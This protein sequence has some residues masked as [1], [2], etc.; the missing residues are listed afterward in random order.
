[1]QH[2]R[3]YT[4]KGM[5]GILETIGFEQIESQGQSFHLVATLPFRLFSLLHGGNK[6]LRLLLCVVSLGRWK[7]EYPGLE[8]RLR[9]IKALAWLMPRLS[10]G[11]LFVAR[12]P[13]APNH[14]CGQPG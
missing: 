14:P 7:P 11:M 5:H 8:L 6:G 10:P 4:F 9:L 3:H 1:V 12:R 2:I 13:L